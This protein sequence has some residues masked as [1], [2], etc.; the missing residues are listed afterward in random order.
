[1]SLKVTNTLTGKKEAFEPRK[2]GEVSMY[3]CGMTV[4]AFPH[5]GH[6]RCYITFDVIKRYL[7]HLGYKVTHIQ[8][9]TDIDDK[10]IAKANQE[11]ITVAEV[12]S[13]YKKAYE[14]DMSKLNILPANDYPLAT[15][16]IPE[17][18]DMIKGLIEGGFAYKIEGDVYFS[19]NAFSGYG[20]LSKRSLDEMRAGE[21]VDIDPRKKD[22]M[23][24]ALWKSSKPE[25]PS[26]DSP[27]G[28]GRPGWHIE[29]SAMSLKYLKSGFDIHG[30]GQDLIFPHHENEIAQSEAYS[31]TEPFVRYWL[32]N[33]FVNLTGEK[34]SKS[35][36]NIVNLRQLLEQYPSQVIRLFV[37]GTHYR[38]PIDF[39]EDGL[40]SARSSLEGLYAAARD[41]YGVTSNS[42]EQLNRNNNREG[43]LIK[44]NELETAFENAMQ[45]D[46]NTAAALSEI[47]ELKDQINLFLKTSGESFSDFDV[48]AIK[49]TRDKMVNLMDV[50]GLSADFKAWL[51]NDKPILDKSESD[52]NA[53]LDDLPFVLDPDFFE[54]DTVENKIIEELVLLRQAARHNKNWTLS[55][56]IRNKLRYKNIIIEDIKGG[57]RIYLSPWQ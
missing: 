43:F 32:H 51:I 40:E 11:S 14:Q 5:L 46:F 49:Q 15:E 29:C 4:Q 28:K 7:I 39:T 20:K 13:K 6:A 24:F 45:D 42:E 25:E 27:W 53:L 31:G 35:T 26:W 44:A 1:M 8:N 17:I 33:G 10:I 16:H 36:G 3:V 23:D 38:S 21:R 30:G 37:I 19:V 55:D 41:S 52:I 9:Y 50:F 12:S 18:I 22:P 56:E 48:A 47:Y 34:M 54:N 2:R 57:T